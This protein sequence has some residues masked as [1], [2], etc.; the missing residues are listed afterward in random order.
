MMWNIIKHQFFHLFFTNGILKLVR[1][2]LEQNILMFLN[3]S[4]SFL[5]PL[6]FVFSCGFFL[7]VFFAGLY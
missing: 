4:P 2:A 1:K 3:N 6:R 7:F 5:N